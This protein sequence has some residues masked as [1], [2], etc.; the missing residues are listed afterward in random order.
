MGNPFK[1]GCAVSGEHFCARK[2]AERDI[3]GFVKSG[4]HV[5]VQGERR[6]GKTSLVRE[7]IGRIRGE[8]LVYIDLYYIGSRSDLCRRIVEGVGRANASMPFLK[9]VMSF[10]SRLRPSLVID[11]TDGS[12]KITVDALAA[13]APDS[14]DSVLTLLEKVADDGKTCVVLDE[15]QD[16]L[17]LP[18][19]DKVLAEMRGRIQFSENVPYF[20]L[21]SVRHEMWRIFNDSKSPFFKSAAAYD[22]GAID[23]DDLAHFL[24]ERFKCG[25]RVA[26]VETALRIIETACGVSGDVQEFC[27]ALW[28][29]TESGTTVS[30]SDF[31]AA[32]GVVFMRERKGFEKAISILTPTQYRVL[33]GLARYGRVRVYGSEF[34]K[35][36]GIP[37]AGAVRKALKRLEDNDLVYAVD[38]EYRFTD[39]FFKE[40]VVRNG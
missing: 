5:F 6:M 20:F 28:D 25:R 8:R 1:Y 40:W 18:D 13:D 21:G 11:P 33:S 10:V 36:I 35:N 16:V 34:L 24:V 32:L 14:L 9:K 38:G 26:T 17:R 29:V 31:E 12:P 19:A 15:F 3:R 23:A 22:V 27:A 30:E 39:S 7:A 37:N 2:K 4:R